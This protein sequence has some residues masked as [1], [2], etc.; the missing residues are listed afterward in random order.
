LERALNIQFDDH[1]DYDN[2]KPSANSNSRNSTFSKTLRT[3]DGQSAHPHTRIKKVALSQN[4]SRKIKRTLP[5]WTTKSYFCT[6]W[7]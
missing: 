1:I 4:Y 5:Q 6:P 7:A 3:K 2:H